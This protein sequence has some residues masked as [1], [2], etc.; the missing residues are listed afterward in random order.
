MPG[1]LAAAAVLAD[2]RGE[3]TAARKAS[4]VTLAKAAWRLRSILN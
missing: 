2:G 4:F 3:K 1:K